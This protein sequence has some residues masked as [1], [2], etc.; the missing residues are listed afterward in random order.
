MAARLD[1]TLAMSY[2]RATLKIATLKSSEVGELATE[3]LRWNEAEHKT[4]PLTALSSLEEVA[5]VHC[6]WLR[7][8]CP[9]DT[10]RQNRRSVSS[11]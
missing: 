3:R 9:Q 8:E 7:A 11:P 10:L 1:R 4:V 6:V 5:L 2:E